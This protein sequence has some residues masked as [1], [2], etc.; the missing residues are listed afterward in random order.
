MSQKFFVEIG[1]SNFQTLQPLLSN[2]WKGLMVEPM[3][4][5]FNEIPSHENLIKEMC[6]VDTKDGFADFWMVENPE[7]F[8][9][10]EE[11]IGMSSLVNSPNAL[12]HETYDNRR[13]IIQVP[14]MRL[15]TLFA[16]HRVKHVDLL[17]V[18]IEG[19]DIEILMDY[20]F[21]IKPS[22]IKFEHVHY[23]GKVY[24]Y[25]AA[26]FNQQEM[27]KNYNRL[28]ERLK[29]MGYI[30]WEEKDDVYCIR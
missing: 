2:G 29:N 8:T 27:T 26:G 1:V 11:V 3:P 22:V 19:K 7:L 12:Y 24:D 23:S 13:K 28:L 5:T 4:Q 25:S 18:D 6:A 9:N 21:R 16:K 20:S 10:S 14:T 15:E 30:I 17:K